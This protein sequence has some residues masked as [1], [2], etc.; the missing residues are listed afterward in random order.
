MEKEG[1]DNFVLKPNSEGGKNNF[2]GKDAF[3]KIK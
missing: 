3:N 2:F 1:I